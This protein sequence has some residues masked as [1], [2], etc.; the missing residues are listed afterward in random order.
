MLG[1]KRITLLLKNAVSTPYT[2]AQCFFLSYASSYMSP[3]LQTAN[4]TYVYQYPHGG[5]VYDGK[6]GMG[7]NGDRVVTLECRS[8]F[9]YDVKAVGSGNKSCYGYAWVSSRDETISKYGNS[10]DNWN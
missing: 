2:L 3:D 5:M 1:G 4:A 6:S 7:L 10:L 8:A 9:F